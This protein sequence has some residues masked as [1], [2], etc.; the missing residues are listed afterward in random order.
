MISWP[1]PSPGRTAILFIA[2]PEKPGKLCFSPLFER[3]DLVGVPQGQ[4]DLVQAVQ[5]RVAARGVDLE[6]VRLRA[7]RG[8]DC[9]A[10]QVHHQPE[11]GE[12]AVVEEAVDLGL[13]QR[14]GKQAVLEADVVEDV[15]ER[16]RDHALEAEFLQGP[17]RV[18][19]RA[20]AA[21]VLARKQDLGPLVARLVQYEVRIERA[22][23]VVLPGLPGV[24]ITPCVKAVRAVAGPQD[25]RKELLRDDRVGVDVRPIERR[26][27]RVEH[28]ELF[29]QLT[30]LTSTKWPAIA[31]AAAIA[32]LTRWVRPPAPCRPSKFRF[33]VA[34]QR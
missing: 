10:L 2:L 13:L 32:G 19:A 1:M 14:D 23:R 30:F 28:G 33:E 7:V 5:Q 20:A 15:A 24:E 22:L 16:G 3:A 12:R 27:E 6:A 21:E 26:D 9:L 34:A 31:A 29:H 18:L 25:R 11:A 17:G 4:A 8:R